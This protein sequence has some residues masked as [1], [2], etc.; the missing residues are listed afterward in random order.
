MLLTAGG[1][2]WWPH[3]WRVDV[4]NKGKREGR[5][6]AVPFVEGPGC[7]VLSNWHK[8]EGLPSQVHHSTTRR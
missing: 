1:K 6:R 2:H 7:W 5:E 3:G 4:S 8:L